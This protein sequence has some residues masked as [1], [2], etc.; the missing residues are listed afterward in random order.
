VSTC[1]RL[2]RISRRT[3]CT[4]ETINT[5][6]R[7]QQP[8]TAP[9]VPDAATAA[10]RFL[11]ARLLLA[12]AEVTT[13][14]VRTTG[15][16]LSSF[17][18]ATH[19][20]GDCLT[21]GLSDPAHL[22]PLMHGVLSTS[23]NGA[24]RAV[25]GLYL[26]PHRDYLELR[27]LATDSNGLGAR[28]RLLGIS[29]QQSREL[30]DS[31]TGAH[32]P[33]R[34]PRTGTTPGQSEIPL[35]GGH[36]VPATAVLSGV[37]RRILLWRAADRLQVSII[38]DTVE[39]C[40]HDGPDGA[41]IAA[42]LGQSCC[43]IP[44]IAISAS[45]V[46]NAHSI[47]IN[48]KD[49][50]TATALVEPWTAWDSLQVILAAASNGT[51]QAPYF[52]GPTV[53]PCVQW[54]KP[55]MRTALAAR[56]V[57]TVYRL[58]RRTGVSPHQIAAM[59]GQSQ[60]EV[61]EILKGRLVTAYHVLARIADGL[62]VPR[63]YMGLAD[64]EVMA[65]RVAETGEDFGREEDES[66]KR[67]KFQAYAAAITVGAHAFDDADTQV[68]TLVGRTDDDSAKGSLAEAEDWVRFFNDTDVYAM[69]GTVQTALASNGLPKLTQHAIPALSRAIESYGDEAARIKAFSLSALATNH[70]L[71]GDI[72]HM[73]G[74]G[75]TAVDLAEHVKSKRI[76]DRLRPL[77]DEADKR[78]GNGQARDLTDVLGRLYVR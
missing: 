50:A 72:D 33:G 62:G 11:E 43:A 36:D 29:R 47:A 10:Q 54:D 76:R 38:G 78:R 15:R 35:I 57:S 5:V 51:A 42:V 68:M 25:P 58:L 34:P 48:R 53:V 22:R 44:R 28:V 16:P 18:A 30:L 75:N 52:K 8:S 66:V 60:S 70:I 63:G 13:E 59:T 20:A 9:V 55:E 64:D 37:L 41:A 3:I 4:G 14:V 12:W 69:I 17:I 67:R 26:Y 40:W 24:V 61:S 74:S 71:D 2:S 27:L 73:R 65:V 19:P 7:L 21:I 1:L 46:G 49:L 45:T 6:R 39:F 32:R 56:D 77:K 31:G 23:E